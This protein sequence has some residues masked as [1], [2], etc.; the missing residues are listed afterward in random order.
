MNIDELT[1]YHLARCSDYRKIV[2]A[3]FKNQ[4]PED[5]YIHAGLFKEKLLITDRYTDSIQYRSSGTSGHHSRIVFSRYDAI[6]QQRHLLKTFKPFLSTK[7][8]R[9]FVELETKTDGVNNARK[10]AARGFSLLGRKRIAIRPDTKGLFSALKECREHDL[11]MVLFGFTFEIYKFLK[12]ID[13]TNVNLLDRQID[14]IHGGGWKKLENERISNK[15]FIKLAQARLGNI[16][17]IN[18]Y[19]MVEQLGLVYP[20]CAEGYFHI[21]SDA[22]IIIRDAKGLR[23]HDGGTGIIQSISPLP[24][25]YPGHSVLTEDLGRIIPGHCLCGRAG[26]RFEFLGRLAH[27]EIRGCSDAY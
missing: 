13:A 26:G 21:S 16:N 3:R 19:G 2:E 9:L 24:K 17:V 20:Q 14:L 15:D 11:D 23:V 22:Q 1:K 6:E 27:A 18:Y 12:N 25:S 5:I 10:A 4:A 7:K 8:N